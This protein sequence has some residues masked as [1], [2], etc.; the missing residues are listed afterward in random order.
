[1][2]A[3]RFLLALSVVLNHSSSNPVLAMVGG[4]VA[5]EGFFVIS[6]FYMALILDTKYRDISLFLSNRALRLL[7]AYL[8]VLIVSYWFF[9]H[10]Y[11]PFLSSFSD[12][13]GLTK[14]VMHLSNVL[15]VGQDVAHFF[16]YQDGAPVF[17]STLA[18]GPHLSQYL[19]VPQAW[20][21]ALEIYF[22]AMA[23]FMV[24]LQTRYLMAIALLLVAI[25]TVALA[26]GLNHEPWIYRF[27]PFELPLFLVGMLAY[28][29][30]KSRHWRFGHA[31]VFGVV[32]AILLFPILEVVV[33]HVAAKILFLCAVVTTLPAVFQSKSSGWDQQLGELSYPL[34]L[35]HI[36]VMRFVPTI[37]GVGNSEALLTFWVVVLSVLASVGLRFAVDWPVDIYRQR[38]LKV[39]A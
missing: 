21:L 24:R 6:G 5:V 31:A 13:D 32:L 27:F 7:P 38:R 34:Y 26:S 19:F 8:V 12:L 2:G 4:E 10:Y 11:P 23:P 29:A 16:V 18:S 30:A 17:S 9:K 28:R 20:T 14:A 39:H 1:M 3:I 25:K 37:D 35:C 15:L 36:A 22:Y 33:G